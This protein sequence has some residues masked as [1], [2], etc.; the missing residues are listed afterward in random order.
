MKPCVADASQHGI[1]RPCCSSNWGGHTE[2]ESCHQL[3]LIFGTPPLTDIVGPTRVAAEDPD[4]SKTALGGGR[5]ETPLRAHGRVRPGPFSIFGLTNG[6]LPPKLVKRAKSPTGSHIGSGLACFGGTGVRQVSSYGPPTT[7]SYVQ[8]STSGYAYRCT[9]FLRAE[10]ALT[11]LLNKVC[12]TKC[13][14]LL[15]ANPSALVA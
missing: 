2:R 9:Q 3:R 10:G 5:L 6:A 15:Q 7:Y 13:E 4:A 12:V 1:T 8:A 14:Q 11:K